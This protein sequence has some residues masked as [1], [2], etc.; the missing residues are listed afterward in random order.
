MRITIGEFAVEMPGGG[1][2]GDVSVRL[3]LQKSAPQ[4]PGG[5]AR[6]RTNSLRVLPSEWITFC[7]ATGLGA[8]FYGDGGFCD[9]RTGFKPL[10]PEHHAAAK[11]A[12]ERWQ[13]LQREAGTPEGAA[14]LDRLTWLEWW[15]RWALANCSKPAVHVMRP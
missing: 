15:M 2:P 3:E 4:T 5:D 8:L 13:D 1:S 14:H 6:D 12:L 7:E 11:E 9:S 10:L